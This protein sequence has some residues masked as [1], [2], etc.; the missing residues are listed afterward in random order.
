ML[1]EVKNIKKHYKQFDLECSMQVKAGSITGLIG[2][3]GA[4]KSTTFKAILDLIHLDGGEVEIFGKNVHDF[5]P[6]EKAKIGNILGRSSFSGYYS[7]S[8]VS[9]IMKAFYPTFDEIN[10]MK[11]VKHFQL[12][13][14]DKIKTFST[15]MKA[16]LKV[17]LAMSVDAKLLILDEPTTGLDV[18]ARDEILDMLREYMMHDMEDR[19]ILI[20]SHIASDLEHLCDDI[21]M[22]DEGKII[23][24]EDTDVLLNDYGLIKVDDLQ[25][26]KID[27]QYILKVKK[28]SFGYSC[29]TNQK[30]FYKDNYSD[31]VVE[32]SGIDE[33]IYMV[34][35]GEAA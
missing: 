32:K 4:G 6:K 1:V 34:V 20:S 9:K 19:A 23:L 28:E 30:Q 35:K 22:I 10:F 16:K 21:Y 2:Q 25:Y 18:V 27:K 15:G 17:L 11:K 33:I 31:L 13:I 26:E 3:N 5:T 7:I 29:L 8:D 12:P 24:H 14:N